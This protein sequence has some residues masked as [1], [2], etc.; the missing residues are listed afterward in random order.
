MLGDPPGLLSISAIEIKSTQGPFHETYLVQFTC[1]EG[2]TFYL[3]GF[4]HLFS[5]VSTFISQNLTHKGTQ[6][7]IF[8]SGVYSWATSDTL[9]YLLFFFS[10]TTAFWAFLSS[11]H[12]SPVGFLQL[13][14]PFLTMDHKRVTLTL[15]LVS[16]AT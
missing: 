15:P 16:E 10:L 5:W 14:S 4:L 11:S 12:R 2:F 8:P 13:L 1:T 6:A 7:V 3:A 9:N